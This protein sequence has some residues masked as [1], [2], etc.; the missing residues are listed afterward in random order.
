MRLLAVILLA[1]LA[2]PLHASELSVAYEDGKTAYVDAGASPNDTAFIA[3]ERAEKSEGPWTKR[4]EIPY[5]GSGSFRDSSFTQFLDKELIEG[6]TYYYRAKFLRAD[7]TEL[8]TTA[9]QAFKNE[10]E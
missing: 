7:K 4:G 1:L 2:L 9:P 6:K 10:E 3:F 5:R 8:A